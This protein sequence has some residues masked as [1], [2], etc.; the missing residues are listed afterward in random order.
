MVA[1]LGSSKL[2]RLSASVSSLG[3]T[4]VEVMEISSS[5]E[6]VRVRMDMGLLLIFLFLLLFFFLQF[7]FSERVDLTDHRELTL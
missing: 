1:G 7:L 4:C 5:D 2:D 6:S 3:S